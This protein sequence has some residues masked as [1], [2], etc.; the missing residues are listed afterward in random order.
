MRLGGLAELDIRFGKGNVRAFLSFS[1]TCKQKL[2]R[3]RGLSA[4]G[5]P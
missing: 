3:K 2:K 4:A 5:G 1:R